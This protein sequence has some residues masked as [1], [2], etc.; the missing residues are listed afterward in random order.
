V[1]G[2]VQKLKGQI[3]CTSSDRGTVFEILLPARMA[4]LQRAVPEPL[5]NEA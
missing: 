4:A 2:L 3:G 5:R 1:Q